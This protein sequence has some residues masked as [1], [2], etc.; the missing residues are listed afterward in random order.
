MSGRFDVKYLRMKYVGKSPD[1]IIKD[2]PNGNIRLLFPHL[3]YSQN[4]CKDRINVVV[5]DGSINRIW[6]N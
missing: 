2:F 1:K 5:V 4:H 3:P 6:I